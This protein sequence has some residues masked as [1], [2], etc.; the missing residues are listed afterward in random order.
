MYFFSSLFGGG[1]KGGDDAAGGVAL[2]HVRGTHEL[3]TR[4]VQ[5]E[6]RAGSLRSSD[7]FV[8]LT[9]AIMYVWRGHGA[10]A[11]EFATAEAIASGVLR[12]ERTVE[13]VLEGS[14]PAAFWE[15][16]GGAAEYA[17]ALPPVEEPR[18]PILFHCSTH[19]NGIFAVDEPILDYSQAVGL[20]LT[21]TLT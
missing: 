20:A 5:V 15:A 9:P 7:C 16:L 11:T 6:A 2:F 14:E 17:T 1:D 4:A 18:E 19:R 3:D 21:L 10:N 8:L 13:A 12:A